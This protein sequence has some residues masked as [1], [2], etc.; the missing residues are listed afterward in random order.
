MGTFLIKQYSNI[1]IT[2]STFSEKTPTYF[3]KLGVYDNKEAM[4]KNTV[5]FNYYIYKEDNNKFHVY[6]AITQSKDN[7]EKLVCL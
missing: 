4:E 2:T 1:P 7:L 3:L 5:D 6:V